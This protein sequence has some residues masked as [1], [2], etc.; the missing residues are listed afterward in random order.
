M[1]DFVQVFQTT[2]AVS[3]M[4][5]DDFV[6]IRQDSVMGDEAGQVAIPRPL[7]K[8]VLNTILAE[9]D[10]HELREIS[11]M[12]ESHVRIELKSKKEG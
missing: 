5:D 10:L 8:E 7:F 3:I 2:G 6:C 4:V 11:E 12:A 1:S 9:I